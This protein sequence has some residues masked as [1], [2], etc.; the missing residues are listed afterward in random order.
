MT[1]N[2]V[3]I[4]MTKAAGKVKISKYWKERFVW[5]GFK[6]DRWQDAP[7]CSGA[8]ERASGGRKSSQRFRRVLQYSRQ[9]DLDFPRRP[10]R[11]SPGGPV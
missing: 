11:A 3:I 8:P 9:K 1:L 4:K 2:E 10:P 7:D 5:D 6:A